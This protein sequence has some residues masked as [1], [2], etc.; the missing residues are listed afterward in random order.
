M[1]LSA[2]GA[3]EHV[4]QDLELGEDG[5]NDASD[6]SK[7]T[8]HDGRN[9]RHCQGPNSE[10]LKKRKERVLPKGRILAFELLNLQ[11]YCPNSL[12]AYLNT[13]I[14]PYKVTIPTLL[15]GIFGK[16]QETESSRASHSMNNPLV[17]HQ[18]CQELQNG[19]EK[20]ISGTNG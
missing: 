20:D 15:E 17:N 6:R 16:F 11:T 13:T 12:R 2:N 5:P 1:S 18:R 14:L 7:E 4:I 10:P 19:H 9:K 8:C 3:Q